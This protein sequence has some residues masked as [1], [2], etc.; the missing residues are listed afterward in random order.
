M[1]RNSSTWSRVFR[2]ASI[3]WASPSRR[4][5]PR[6]RRGWR[7]S[8]RVVLY[9]NARLIPG[10]G[11]P[12]IERAAMLVRDG[13]ITRVGR[14]GEVGLPQGGARVDLTGKT[15]IPTLT[16]A[17]THVGFQ[18]G[19]TYARE[20]YGRESILE[21]LEPRALLRRHRGGVAGH[22]SGR[23]RAA[24]PRRAGGAHA[25]RRAPLH[26]RAAASGFPTPVPAPR[27]IV[28]SPTRS[29]RRS[30]GARPYASRRR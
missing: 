9:E 24:H 10:D 5:P 13:R 7:T 14:A 1:P 21:D 8:A 12:A 11:Q 15:V 23:R 29:P 3:A 22:R 19:A 25:R 30:R 27:A 16:N 4:S 28:V 2:P 6:K 17:H 20:N 26:R 18:R